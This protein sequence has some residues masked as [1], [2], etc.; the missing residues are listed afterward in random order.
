[1]EHFHP[2]RDRRRPAPVRRRLAIHRRRRLA[3][4]AAAMRGIEIAL[5]GRSNVGKSSLINALTGRKALARTSRTP[6]RTQEL[7]F[8]NGGGELNLV[9]MPG[10]GYAA[11]AKSQDRGLDR[12]D[13]R[14][15]ARARQPRPRLRAGRRPP[16][17][18]GHRRADARRARQGR[19]Q[20]PDRAHQGRRGDRRRSLPAH[21]A[22]S[23]RRWPS[24]RPPFPRC[25]RPRR[26]R[27][28]ASRSCARR[29]PGCWRSARRNNRT[30]GST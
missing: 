3:G 21:R 20:P 23:R 30:D 8:F 6:G 5:A 14:L 1:M 10:Y 11:A 7:I 29:S 17:A 16:R 24:A 25:W 26:T 15:L 12:A 9:D 13:P 27:A 28:P 18:E 4:L 19:G 2:P 22:R